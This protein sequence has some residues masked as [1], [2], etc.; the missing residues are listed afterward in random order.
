M[1]GWKQN[2]EATD[3]AGLSSGE[4]IWGLNEHCECGGQKEVLQETLGLN[5]PITHTPCFLLL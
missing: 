4:L 1:E 3:G 5:Q 2:T